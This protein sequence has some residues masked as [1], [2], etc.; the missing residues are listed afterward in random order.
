[1]TIIEEIKKKLKENQVLF[2]SNGKMDYHIPG[3]LAEKSYS[4]IRPILDQNFRFYDGSDTGPKAY[5]YQIFLRMINETFIHNKDSKEIAK[6]KYIIY[7]DE[8]CFIPRLDLLYKEFEEFKISGKAFAGIPD[9]GM[10]CHRNHNNFAI[11][12]FLTFFN[13]EVLYNTLL[14]FGAL[15]IKTGSISPRTRFEIDR[16]SFEALC[17]KTSYNHLSAIKSDSNECLTFCQKLRLKEV[18]YTETVKNDPNNP[19]EPN[20]VPYSCKLD[21]MEP[22]YKLFFY[23]M[24]LG[25][26]PKYLLGSDFYKD[27]NGTIVD[28]MGGI[29]SVIYSSV[30]MVPLCYHTWFARDYAPKWFFEQVEAGSDPHMPEHTYNW[31]KEHS[32]RIDKVFEYCKSISDIDIK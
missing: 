21:D 23:F 15:D 1:M 2:V 6:F 30:E 25:L 12:T 32:E 8:D 16:M 10:V 26:K 22:Y 9:G 27:E 13:V 17:N 31:M 3:S 28:D 24:S 5:G 7:F 14:K 4:F 20:Q 11:N 29:T 19:V 18:P